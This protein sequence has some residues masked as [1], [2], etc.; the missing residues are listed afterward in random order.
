MENDTHDDPA[1]DRAAEPK[2]SRKPAKFP[3]RLAVAFAGLALVLVA[4]GFAASSLRSCVAE[5]SQAL[6]TRTET[7]V[8]EYGCSL[9]REGKLIL[10]SKTSGFL[11]PRDFAKRLILGLEST[12]KIEIACQAV[13]NFYVDAEDLRAADYSWRGSK[14]TL[15]VAKPR[16]MRPLI[17]TSTIRKAILDRGFFFNEEAELDVLLSRLSDIVAASDDARPDE[18][19]LESSR[20]SLEEMA[21]TA[22]SGMGKKVGALSVE[23]K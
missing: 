11:V 10:A 17:E 7:R 1:P 8:Y 14:L 21:A 5:T 18:A 20:R 3:L 6:R 15:R 23:W 4:L 16:A 9:S 22:L 13:I 12:A 19:A 2:P